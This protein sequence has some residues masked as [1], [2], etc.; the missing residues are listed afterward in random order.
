MLLKL[1]KMLKLV[2]FNTV[3]I[4]AGI[5]HATIG[6]ASFEAAALRENLDA[7]VDALLKAKPASAKGVY[8]KKI[9]V[10]STMGVGARVDQASFLA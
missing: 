8:L 10:S 9:A 5:V 1:L 4:K 2:R 7:L 6:R 3:L